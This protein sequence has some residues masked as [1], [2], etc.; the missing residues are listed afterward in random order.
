VD[1]KSGLAASKD[2][3]YSP[4]AARGRRAQSGGGIVS[5]QSGRERRIWMGGWKPEGWKE[6]NSLSIVNSYLSRVDLEVQ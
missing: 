4:H 6:A 2:E 5:S 1:G 3:V